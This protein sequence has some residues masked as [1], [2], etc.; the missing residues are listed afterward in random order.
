MYEEKAKP[1]LVKI[2]ASF[3]RGPRFELDLETGYNEAS[4]LLFSPVPPDKHCDSISKY[5]TTTSFQIPS[6][7]SYLNIL[8]CYVIHP[9]QLKELH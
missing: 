6:N 8:P 5:S 3:S 2:P 7:P 4:F 9:M 1:R